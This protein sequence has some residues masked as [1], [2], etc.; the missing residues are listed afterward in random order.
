MLKLSA[1]VIGVGLVSIEILVQIFNDGACSR[2]ASWLSGVYIGLGCIFLSQGDTLEGVLCFLPTL[3][4]L[5]AHW[6]KKCG[7]RVTQKGGIA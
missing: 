5:I 3:V 2:F 7:Q 1:V 4:I 6:A